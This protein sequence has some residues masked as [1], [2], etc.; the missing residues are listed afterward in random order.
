MRTVKVLV[1]AAVLSGCSGVKRED[2][3]QEWVKAYCDLLVKCGGAKSAEGCV[4][5]Y[6]RTVTGSSALLFSGAAYEKS[7]AAN[8]IRFDEGRAGGCMNALRGQSCDS[9]GLGVLLNEDCARIY[10]GTVAEGQTCNP[11]ECAWGLYCSSELTATCGGTCVRRVGEGGS[12]SSSA[13]CAFGLRLING[14]CRK[15]LRENESCAS[16]SLAELFICESP[17]F[18]DPTLKTC[19]RGRRENETC[20]S[21]ATDQRCVGVALQCVNGTCVKPA[22]VGSACGAG[23]RSCKVDLVCAGTCQEPFAEGVSCRT[24]NECKPPLV[25]SGPLGSRVCKAPVL[26]G[27]SCAIDSCDTPLY[28]DAATQTCLDKRADGQAC[29]SS[30]QCEAAFCNTLGKPDAGT[31]GFGLDLGC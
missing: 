21:A 10:E 22:D 18:C 30:E 26:E 11:G 8:K 20:S 2:L 7:I 4:A 14:I 24:L 9:D 13:Q 3:A 1:A 19:K 6:G 29:T 28:C 23:E 15:P 27:Q 5:L 16:S 25:C 17:L 31:C 12:A